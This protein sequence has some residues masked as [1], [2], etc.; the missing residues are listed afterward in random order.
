VNVPFHNIYKPALEDN[1]DPPIPQ[2]PEPFIA[3]SLVPQ[4]LID[5]VGD[6]INEVGAKYVKDFAQGFLESDIA[7]LPKQF[8][9]DVGDVWELV[10]DALDLMADAFESGVKDAKEAFDYVDEI[11]DSK[12]QE[13]MDQLAG[14]QQCSANENANPFNNLVHGELK[15]HQTSSPN[16][17]CSML[18]FFASALNNEYTEEQDDCGSVGFGIYTETIGPQLNL[19]FSR[20]YH[21]KLCWSSF[22]PA[23]NNV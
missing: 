16:P 15:L 18:H 11:I 9:D 12:S 23:M 20:K 22:V 1:S 14:L 2:G 13:V 10:S 17:L 21:L 5:G 19:G 3:E 4:A 7:E 8:L 6:L